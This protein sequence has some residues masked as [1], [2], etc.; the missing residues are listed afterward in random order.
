MHCSAGQCG[1]QQGCTVQCRVVQYR[2][3]QY[4][5]VQCSAVQELPSGAVKGDM[6]Q[7]KREL[8]EAARKEADL[9]R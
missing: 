9:A 2:A 8:K 3:V 6:V 1:A 4:S 5:A 7:L